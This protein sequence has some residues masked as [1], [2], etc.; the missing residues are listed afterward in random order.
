MLQAQTLWLAGATLLTGLILLGGSLT[1]LARLAAD[2]LGWNGPT[3][4]VAAVGVLA[5]LGFEIFFYDL[6]AVGRMVTG[7]IVNLFRAIGHLLL[8]A[9]GWL[10]VRLE[11]ALAVAAYVLA[12]GGA[13]LAVRFILG[14]EEKGASSQTPLPC[15][16]NEPGPE[17]PLHRLV[18]RTVARGW[19][20]QVSALASFL[21]LRLDLAG[22]E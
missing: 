6:L 14:R 8:L 15:V 17:I 22:W 13:V 2:H 12:Q 7:P 3:A 9:A 11:L 19:L 16:Q 18:R 21:H 4:V 10:L 20:G 1:P 5:L